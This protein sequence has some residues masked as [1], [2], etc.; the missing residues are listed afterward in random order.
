[1]GTIHTQTITSEGS[2]GRLDVC[3][4]SKVINVDISEDWLAW[5]RRSQKQETLQGEGS[6]G[7][8]L[9]SVRI[10]Q[11]RHCVLI[12]HNDSCSGHLDV[13]RRATGLAGRISQI[14][15][16]P[17]FDG[18]DRQEILRLILKILEPVLGHSG[19]DNLPFK[20]LLVY[21]KKV[22]TVADIPEIEPKRLAVLEQDSF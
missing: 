9:P 1:M 14:T 12:P 7:Q 5:E 3:Q 20:A 19:A 10:L 15:D 17:R 22:E 18:A 13:A 8:K 6:T 11:G 2:V 16:E 21:L 4:H